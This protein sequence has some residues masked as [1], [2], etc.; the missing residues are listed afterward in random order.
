MAN[1]QFGFYESPNTNKKV[2][3]WEMEFNIEIHVSGGWRR[4]VEQKTV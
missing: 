3:F 4:E 1:G 2:L